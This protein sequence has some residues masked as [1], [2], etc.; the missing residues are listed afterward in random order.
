MN[1]YFQWLGLKNYDTAL[2]AQMDAAAN[3]QEGGRDVV[4]ACEH[5]NII[6]L[7]KRAQGD[8]EFLVSKATLHELKIDIAYVDRG[9]Q[10]VFHNPGQLV[11]YPIVSLARHGLTIKEYVNLLEETTLAFL[12]SFGLDV[13]RSVEPG[14][15]VGDKKIAYFGVRI[16]QGVSRHGVAINIKNDVSVFSLIKQCGLKVDATSLVEEVSQK[17]ALSNLRDLSHVWM[18]FFEEKLK[19]ISKPKPNISP[20]ASVSFQLDA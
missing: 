15:W 4:L 17:G 13:H 18:K 6:T 2:K 1:I 5:P 10:A 16:D 9:G 12:E 14:L 19:T 11:I 20:M 7:G 8:A 3:V